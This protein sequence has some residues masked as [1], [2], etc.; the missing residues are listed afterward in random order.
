MSL[1]SL[2]ILLS[3]INGIIV[4]IT[5]THI[6]LNNTN[7]S[8]MLGWAGVAIFAPIIGPLL[9][10]TFGL[11]RVRRRAARLESYHTPEEL[12]AIDYQPTIAANHQLDIFRTGDALTPY[13]LRPCQTITPHL[14]PDD[15]Y[16]AM[17]TAIRSA[18]HNVSLLTYIFDA[19]HVGLAFVRELANA[20]ERG[21]TVRVIIDGIG[22]LNQR[23]QIPPIYRALK[24]H[25]I[26]FAKFMPPRLL[27]PSFS[28][29][30]RNHRKLLIID[31]ETA[32]TG[33][34]NIS[35]RYSDT[36]FHYNRGK[37]HQRAG[38]AE[39]IS[40]IHCQF[41]GAIVQQYQHIF[42]CDWAFTQGLPLPIYQSIYQPTD[43]SPLDK[44]G[45][46]TCQ[47]WARAISD[48]PSDELNRFS[49]LFH[50]MVARAKHRVAIVT[51]YFIPSTSLL[52][53]MQT[54]ALYG[55]EVAI[56]LPETLD[57]H[58]VQW[59]RMHVMAE[60]IESGTKVF[61]RQGAFAHDKLLLV[62]DHYV[63]IGS[64]NWDPRSLTL[65]YEAGVECWSAELS[66]Q[67]WEYVDTI[68]A[69]SRRHTLTD[70]KQIGLLP[71][72]RNSLAW[73]FSAYL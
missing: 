70:C 63:F 19:D 72:L 10:F 3:A 22:A 23:L 15:A 4:A 24:R 55:V 52:D 48:T 68:A 65:N 47:T 71:R 9:Y 12:D 36:S 43:Q 8:S 56:Y 61:L 5:V 41:S 62:D 26:T 7:P 2:T 18:Q 60:T 42:D 34:L 14:T 40:D 27:P 28:I 50:S 11:S 25:D 59:A 44:P 35:Q 16:N 66:Q 13:R 29:N 53:A 21:V 49:A 32:F 39:A 73:T 31:G 69:Q 38:F 37:R 46:T 57:Q 45:D 54:A 17:L 51:P 6:L 67:L 1:F 58:L 33:G 20:K 30:L 64:P